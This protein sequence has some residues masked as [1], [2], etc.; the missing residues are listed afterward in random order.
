M[1]Y[2]WIGVAILTLLGLI[3]GVVLGFAAHKFKVEEDPL[4]DTID[5]PNVV[6]PAVVLM[7]MRLLIRM[8]KSINVSRVANPLCLK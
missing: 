6:I 5:V 2:F 7:R 3:C 1:Y 4:T 8:K